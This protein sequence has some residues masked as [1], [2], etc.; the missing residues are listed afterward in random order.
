MQI[1]Q[2][3]QHEKQKTSL[4]RLWMSRNFEISNNQTH[5]TYLS[6]LQT[7]RDIC[8]QQKLIP[9]KDSKL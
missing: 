3:Q 6:N 8:S 1:K 9:T 5:R 2:Q 4:S 7:N